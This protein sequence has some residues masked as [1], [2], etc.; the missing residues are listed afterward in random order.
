VVVLRTFSKIHGLAGLR[1]GYAIADPRM[2]LILRRLQLPFSVN[3]LAEAAAVAAVGD[4]SFPVQ[5]RTL[6]FVERARMARAFAAA[7]IEYVP[8]HGNFLL[9]RVGDGR[10]V[11]QALQ[12]RGVIVRPVDNYQLPQ[13]LRVSIGLAHENDLFLSRLREVL[14]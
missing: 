3:A 5:A 1:V 4:E 7:G 13:W 14:A 11:F 12:R 8:S 10:A 6:N 9:L 2:V